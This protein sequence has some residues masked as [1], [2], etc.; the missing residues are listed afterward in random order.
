MLTSRIFGQWVGRS[1]TESVQTRCKIQCDDGEKEGRPSIR[2][3]CCPT[4]MTITGIKWTVTF[5]GN[6]VIDLVRKLI[7][8]SVQLQLVL[9]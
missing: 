7:M 9:Q 5:P 4:Y 8:K 2:G 3:A 6:C 1:A